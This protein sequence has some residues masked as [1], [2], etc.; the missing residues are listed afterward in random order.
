MA[1]AGSSSED[2]LR[3][4]MAR[5]CSCRDVVLQDTGQ[6]RVDGCSMVRVQVVCKHGFRWRKAEQQIGRQ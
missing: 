5:I 1:K 3:G 6:Q 4:A 2:D